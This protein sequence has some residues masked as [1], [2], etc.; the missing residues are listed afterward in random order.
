MTNNLR[1]NNTIAAVLMLILGIILMLFPNGSM[2]LVCT[3]IGWGVL[4]YGVVNLARAVKLGETG[5]AIGMGVVE[6]LVGIFLIANP[7]FLASIIPWIIGLVMVVNGIINLSN[8]SRNRDVLG[9]RYL[10]SFIGG[11]IMVIFGVI[12]LFNAY[13]AASVIVRVIGFGLILSAID[14][15]VSITKK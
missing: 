14:N 13:F 4:I 5:V 8:A 12:I 10:P 6:I 3:L 11:I 7:G 2:N 15:L 1:T 9:S